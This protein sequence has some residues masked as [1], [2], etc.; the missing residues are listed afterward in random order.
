[1]ESE[2]EL[3]PVNNSILIEKNYPT[4]SSKGH[5]GRY[6]KE[7]KKFFDIINE[8]KKT[9]DIIDEGNKNYY[10]VYIYQELPY[11]PNSN[12]QKKTF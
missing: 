1:L 5:F 7:M 8:K 2:E 10:N 12:F 4:D 9:K 11:P 6:L 3:N